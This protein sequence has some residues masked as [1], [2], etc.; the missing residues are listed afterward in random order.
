MSLFNLDQMLGACAGRLAAI[1]KLTVTWATD[2][3]ICY[4]SDLSQPRRI[5]HSR[6]PSATCVDDQQEKETAQRLAVRFLAIVEL[7]HQ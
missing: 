7:T 2:L 3:A 6:N 5:P 1:R 4:L